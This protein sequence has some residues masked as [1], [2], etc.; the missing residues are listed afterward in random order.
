MEVKELNKLAEKLESKIEDIFK[1][2]EEQGE[3]TT[4]LKEELEKTQGELKEVTKSLN[5]L[6]TKKESE[7]TAH[8]IVKNED[9]EPIIK[10]DRQ[11]VQLDVKADML[12]SSHFTGDVIQPQRI[13]GIFADPNKSFHLRQI[14]PILNVNSKTV[15]FTQEDT[16]TDNTNV[17]SEGA[18]APQ[19]EISFKL[20]K[21]SV[22]KIN[23][24]V[25][26]SREMLEDA[27]WISSYIRTRL[28]DKLLVKEDQQ[29]LYGNG[30][31][32]Q[33]EGIT[34]VAQAYADAL[35]DSN[36]TIFDVLLMAS[37]QA[38]QL[39]YAPDF[40]LVS[41]EDYYKMLLSKDGNG[42]FV[43]PQAVFG[44][45]EVR[46][47]GRIRIIPTTALSGNDFIVGDFR[48]G[49]ALGLKKDVTLTIS[50]ENSTNVIDGKVTL[51]LEERIVVQNYRPN[52]FVYGDM[53]SAL[54]LGTA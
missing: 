20:V 54:A 37:K 8:L 52:A 27:E 29:I 35:A 39:E 10:K 24:Y 40:A 41:F 15:E 22:E 14:L 19:S 28:G 17:V 46:L 3:L 45:Q 44:G 5:D 31:S 26:V 18:T 47:G 23:T 25:N 1:K 38:T 11:A 50:A 30:T 12:I 42:A 13:E 2:S 4:N 6:L 33:V 7:K 16:I 21:K 34:T 48:R 9:L 51:L 49:A 43:V 53:A 36:V 32:P